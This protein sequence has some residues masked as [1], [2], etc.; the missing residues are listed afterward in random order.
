LGKK[1]QRSEEFDVFSNLNLKIKEFFRKNILRYV[2]SNGVKKF[3]IFVHL[4]FF[5][6]IRSSIKILT[7]LDSKHLKVFL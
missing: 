1:K 3:Q 5:V 2:E 4:V 7:P 6:G